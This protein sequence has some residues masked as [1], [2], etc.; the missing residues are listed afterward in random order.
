M[1]LRGTNAFSRVNNAGNASVNDRNRVILDVGRLLD[2]LLHFADP[3]LLQLL[4]A[5]CK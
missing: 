5:L 1:H 3:S 2:V 4:Q